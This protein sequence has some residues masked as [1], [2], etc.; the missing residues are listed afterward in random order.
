[1]VVCATVV[2]ALGCEREATFVEPLSAYAA[3]HWVNAVPDT[4][5]Q[6]YRIVD[7]VS[8]AGLYD[9]NFR[10]SNM[11]YQGIEAGSR[12]VR[13]FLSDTTP[14]IASQVLQESS[15]SLTQG[16]SYT[17]IHA[18]F[19]RT[20]QTP[21]RTV[22][23]LQDQP[24]TPAAGQIGVRIVNAG[25]GLGNVDAW[26]VKRAVNPTT[27]DSLLD[28]RAVTNLAFGAVGAYATFGRDSVAADTVRVVFTATGTKTPILAAVVAPA[29][30]PGSATASPIA[31][32][33]VALSVMTS[34]LVPRSV[35]G[36]T[37]PQTA[38]FTTPTVLYLV[39]R[40]P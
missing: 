16:T 37:A 17:Y 31:G 30:D 33:R 22:L 25:A 13:V 40:R 10:G 7:I 1:L 27:A 11:F 24:P 3:I 6:D 39:D 12:T 32:S 20:G 34:V 29:G 2:A 38:A 18:G 4:M 15:L 26:V 14:A 8:N 19:A 21:A 9:Q 23:L 36:S 5:Q 35:A 28:A